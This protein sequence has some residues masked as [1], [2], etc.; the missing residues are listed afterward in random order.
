MKFIIIYSTFKNK[1]EADKIVKILLDKKLIACANY[2]NIESKYFWKDK[3][4]SCKEII[5]LLKT[6]KENW[7]KVKKCIE[8]NHSYKIPCIIKMNEVEANKS[9]SEWVLKETK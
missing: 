4:V 9:Y 7:E 1:K 6:R 3:I 5:T 8:E 2:I